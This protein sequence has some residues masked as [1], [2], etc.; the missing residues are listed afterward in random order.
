MSACLRRLFTTFRYP[1]MPVT[2]KPISLAVFDRP[3]VPFPPA[4]FPL[5]PLRQLLPLFSPPSINPPPRIPAGSNLHRKSLLPGFT[6]VGHVVPAAYPRTRAEAVVNDPSQYDYLTDVFGDVNG[7]VDEDASDSVRRKA[8]KAAIKAAGHKSREANVQSPHRSVEQA[9]EIAKQAKEPALWLQVDRYIPD[10]VA[11]EGHPEGTSGRNDTLDGTRE[12]PMGL[13]LVFAHA[14]GFIKE[15]WEPTFKRIIEELQGSNERVA[16]IINIDFTSH[17]ASYA[18]NRGRIGS[19]VDWS[20]HARD[21]IS[22]LSCLPD[23]EEYAGNWGTY[24]PFRSREGQKR[25]RRLVG[26][27]HSVGG[28]AMTQAACQ[29]PTLFERIILVDG[30]NRVF[31]SDIDNRFGPTL[32]ESC[33]GRRNVWSSRDEARADLGRSPYFAVWHPEV[34]G[35]LIEHGLVDLPADSPQSGVTL[36]CP[37]WLEAAT[38]Q[39][40]EALSAAWTKLGYLRKDLPVKQIIA[41][42]TSA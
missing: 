14:T 2:K 6:R 18:L 21:I 37:R 5:P 39:D 30:M 32:A 28:N 16:E 4:D 12:L 15:M 33:I 26:I 40:W 25:R 23:M 7:K 9:R 38:F 3:A 34:F 10:A 19:V 1:A 31:V 41:G 17:G 27:G 8:R 11:S 42:D 20:D 22:V 35:A 24:L 36:A 29:H 13:T